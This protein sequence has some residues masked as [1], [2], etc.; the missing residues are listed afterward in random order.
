MVYGTH[1]PMIR[2]RHELARLGPA[3]CACIGAVNAQRL[4]K[5]ICRLDAQ[6]MWAIDE[7]PR[8][9]PGPH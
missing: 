1:N 4:G 8:T 9:V 2:L 6:E 5:R 3:R 7:G